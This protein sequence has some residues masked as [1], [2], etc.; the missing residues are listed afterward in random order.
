M[1]VAEA[2]RLKQFWETRYEHFSLSESGWLGAGE[3]KNHYL[4]SCKT[5]ALR[6][7]L[8]SL[9]L[10][11]DSNFAILDAGF[12][13][14]YFPEFY[15]NR[16]PRAD[17]TGI[18]ISAKVIDHLKHSFSD[19]RFFAND[20]V[21][22]RDP[23]Q[24]RFDVI[25]SFEVLHLILDDSLIERAIQSFRE[26]LA[27][28]G[29]LLLTAVLPE[30][31]VEPNHYIRFRSRQWYGHLFENVSLELV[32]ERSM[33][34]WLPDGLPGNRYV[35]GALRKMG[36]VA[37]YVI[38]RAALSLRFPQFNSGLDSRMKLLSLRAK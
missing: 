3:K 1:P 15:R 17:Y 26:Q 19:Y 13:Q 9:R 38:D 37:L 24:K 30:E 6:A 34:Y 11:K 14:G 35:S 12:G 32:S 28:G 2:E 4:Y 20:F 18:D 31:P 21:G 5:Q 7:A 29:H 27:P 16:F 23:D 10:D 25:Q 22:W 33:Y 36:V 8:K